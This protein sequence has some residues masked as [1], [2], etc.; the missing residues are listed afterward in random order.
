MPAGDIDDRKAPESE[1]ERRAQLD[2]LVVGP[3]IDAAR[4]ADGLA[5]LDVAEAER[6]RRAHED[7]ARRIERET[8]RERARAAEEAVR[9]QRE[10][11]QERERQVQLARS[12][13]VSALSD[14]FG[15]E[16]AGLLDAVGRLSSQGFDGVAAE[17]LRVAEVGTDYRRQAANAAAAERAKKLAAEKAKAMGCTCISLSGFAPANRLRAMGAVN[18]YVASG[19]YGFV[20]TA[21]QA[22]LH[23]ILDTAMGWTTETAMTQPSRQMGAAR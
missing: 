3:E 22:V 7:E 17:L 16:A 8:E 6:V 1:A 21:H 15:R 11:D 4:G 18:F 2:A 9:A 10:A 19:V 23:A 20:E 5:L 13:R 14:A 12:E